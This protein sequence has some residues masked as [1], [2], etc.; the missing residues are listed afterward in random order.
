MSKR[1][2]IRSLLKTGPGGSTSQARVRTSVIVEA[3]EGSERRGPASGCPIGKAVRPV[4]QQR[5]NQALRFPVGLRPIGTG[6]AMPDS[7]R[8]RDGGK[9]ERAI[10]HRVIRQQ[11]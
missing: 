9:D 10:G 6:E 7:P 5:L 1:L 3:H 4:A 11:P 2:F 8:P